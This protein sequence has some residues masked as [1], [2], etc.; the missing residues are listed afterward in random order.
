MAE[1]TQILIVE[2]DDRLAETMVLLLERAGYPVHRASQAPEGLDLARQ[3]SPD[4]LVVDGSYGSLLAQL[5]EDEA[6]R[7]I[8]VLI[9]AGMGEEVPQ[10]RPPLHAILEKPFKPHQ[11]LAEVE[12]LL[13]LPALAGEP[14]AATVLVVDDDPDF[15]QIVSRIL[16]ANGYRV[17]TAASGAEAWRQMQEERPDLVLLDIMMTTVLDGLGVSQRMRQDP[18]LKHVPIVMVSSIADT[19]YA[20]VFPTDQYVHMDAWIGKPVDPESLLR[21]VRQHL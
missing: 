16:Q 2:G 3:M 18:A 13:A 9:L 7:H 21:T 1:E 20:A 10:P 6:L 17:R 15:S 11:L 12:E 19:E 4:L 5:C 14:P 8:P